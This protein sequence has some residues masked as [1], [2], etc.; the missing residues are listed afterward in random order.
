MATEM[1]AQLAAK[2]AIK[3]AAFRM[4]PNSLTKNVQMSAH[5][6]SP[7]AH[8]ILSNMPPKWCCQ[9]STMGVESI[10]PGKPAARQS[11]VN[12]NGFAFWRPFRRHICLAL[13]FSGG[14]FCCFGGHFSCRFGGN[15]GGGLCGNFG[16]DFCGNF[17][18]PFGG[19][20]GGHCCAIRAVIFAAIW[21][22]VFCGDLGG[23]FCGN[24]GGHFGSKS[25]RLFWWPLWR[26]FGR[27]LRRLFGGP[28]TFLLRSSRI[29][30]DI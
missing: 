18:G 4:V 10:V 21:A 20:F 8:K 7:N 6:R 26:R 30:W 14:H 19:N 28:P 27:P 29:T 16:G 9:R 22:D 17:G 13:F 23:H 1:A 5:I 15:L 11:N 2:N 3:N 25:W 24:F 12:Y